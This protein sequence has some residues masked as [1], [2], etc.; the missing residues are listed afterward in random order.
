MTDWKIVGTTDN[1][2]TVEYGRA[3]QP[4]R[5]NFDVSSL[6][7]PIVNPPAVPVIGAGIVEASEVN[8]NG[9]RASHSIL[10]TFALRGQIIPTHDHLRGG[11]HD[12]RVLAGEALIRKESGDV[13]GKPGD[14]YTVAVGEKHSVEAL[15]DGT[16]TLHVITPQAANG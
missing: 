8:T 2:V 15:V 1:Q 4:S 3:D 14:V 16:V 10:Y 7:D 12:I 5:L 6:I 9:P 11:L 13:V